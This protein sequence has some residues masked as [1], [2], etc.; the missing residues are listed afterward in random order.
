[1]YNIPKEYQSIIQDAANA[2]YAPNTM[3][4]HG[5]AK[6]WR[7]NLKKPQPK[8]VKTGAFMDGIRH[9]SIE[10]LAKLAHY[11]Q[12]QFADLETL[13]PECDYN[14]ETIFAFIQDF[15]SNKNMLF[16]FRQIY[17]KSLVPNI[18]AIPNIGV[19]Y[20]DELPYNEKINSVKEHMRSENFSASFRWL[21]KDLLANMPELFPE[22]HIKSYEE[23][24]AENIIDLTAFI[25][26]D[27][28]I[29]PNQFLYGIIG[30]EA[31][32][33]QTLLSTQYYGSE[34]DARFYR[35]LPPYQSGIIKINH[36]RW[37][38]F[39]VNSIDTANEECDIALTDYIIDGTNA[40]PTMCQTATFFG[41]TE[42]AHTET[43]TF[44]E[45]AIQMFADP[46]NDKWLRNNIPDTMW[47][48]D[49]Y[50][51]T[52]AALEWTFAKTMPLRYGYPDEDEKLKNPVENY[53]NAIAVWFSHC[54]SWLN[55]K[56]ATCYLSKAAKPVSSLK[57]QT[58]QIADPEKQSER[59]VRYLD[60]I[61]L[62][63]SIRPVAARRNEIHYHTPVWQVRG[64]MRHYKNGHSVWIAPTVHKRKILSGEGDVAPTT[65]KL[66]E[67]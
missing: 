21:M 18:I 50:F 53:T 60:K 59:K 52:I 40:I 65:L 38:Y 54:M 48:Y 17:M 28:S 26:N 23:L 44:A 11:R 22:F 24:C 3:K 27:E 37:L 57:S 31:P 34:R 19:R 12:M 63:S 15:C 14:Y 16:D 43:F 45:L 49:V 61:C 5:F 67:N 20:I 47:F 42:K 55:Y 56:L 35:W 9:K 66:H 1:M 46:E 33:V 7:E 13:V 62:T 36:K 29:S 6:M 4:S 32:T 51:R 2:G 41:S 64:Y 30:E 8:P 10:F 39:H 25:S 58:T